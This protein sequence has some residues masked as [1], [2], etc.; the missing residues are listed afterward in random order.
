MSKNPLVIIAGPTASGK[1]SLSVGLAKKLDGEIISAD[2]MQVYKNM[3]I[4]S[5]KISLEEMESVP[6]HMIDIIEPVEDYNVTL[7]KEKAKEC[8][9]QITERGHLPIIVGGTGFYIQA[10]LYDIDFK[11]EDAD[12]SYRKELE[13]EAKKNGNE[14]LYKRLV[15]IDSASAQKI[16]PN[17]TK[18]LI[19][20]LEYFHLTGEPISGHNELMRRKDSPYSFCYF[21]LYKDRE[22]LYE[23]IEKRVDGMMEQGFLQEVEALK[24]SGVTRRMTSMQGLGYR[25]LYDYLEGKYPLEEALRL[26]KRNTRHFAKRQLTWF[27]R[28][29]DVIWVNKDDYKDNDELVSY[30]CEIIHD[31]IGWER[32]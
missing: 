18:R 9:A 7:F 32:R 24:K 31:K 10:L 16:H 30:M 13:E 8:A 17:N 11:E 29:R 19:R 5:A 1:S 21:V 27:K 6:H 23:N 25:E 22:K 28:E 2:S 15:E 20:A 14:S 3:D 4:G 12:R 26:I